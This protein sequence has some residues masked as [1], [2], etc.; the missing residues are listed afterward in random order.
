MFHTRDLC[1]AVE[2]EGYP[3]ALVEAVVARLLPEG[4]DLADG[5]AR[6]DGE[7][8]VRWSG[9]VILEA[10]GGAGMATAE[11]LEEW[12][13]A[14]PEVWRGEARLESIKVGEGDADAEGIR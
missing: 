12:A 6:V 7:K 1:A 9:M 2:D 14:L 5:W 3:L 4:E 10:R 11:F 13:N 8:C